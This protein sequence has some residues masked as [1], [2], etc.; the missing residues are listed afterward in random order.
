M[1][2]LFCNITYMNNYMGIT[3]DDTSNK[4]GKWVEQNKDAHEQWNFLNYDG[5]C[6]GFVMN[7]GEQFAI[8]RIDESAAGHN[9]LDDVTVVW[10]ALTPAGETMVVGWYEHATVYRNYQDSVVTPISGI[11][12]NY[13]CK[14]KAEDSYLLPEE[15][16][17]IV[18]PRAS[19]A[20][21]GKG[22][23]QQNY[24]YADSG[25]ARTILIPEVVSCLEGL[26]DKRINRISSDFEEPSNVTTPPTE[27]EWTMAY[28]CFNNGNEYEFLP[29]GYRKFYSTKSA[30]DAFN[31]AEALCALHQ[32][33]A[34]VQWYTK[35]IEI[36]GN[37]WDNDS[38]MP[39]LYQQI[40][41]YEESTNASMALLEYEEA[42]ETAVKHEIYSIIA[43]NFYYLGNIK[44]A[45]RWLDKILDESN[46]KEIILHTISVKNNWSMLL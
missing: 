43:D 28:N 26:K 23:G 14:A 16:R 33:E 34:A 35:V 2:I 27:E 44:E 45:V 46:D 20:G 32:Y 22:F 12:R 5:Y 25:F 29:Y 42:S 1:K 17:K 40:K 39:Y 31:I 11:D 30:D 38:R 8:E 3:N 10:C 36:E 4:G 7:H 41:R 9:E 21:K 6:Y 19:A 18:I 37:S 15:Y 13:F 24:W